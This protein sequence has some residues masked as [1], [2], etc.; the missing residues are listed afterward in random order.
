MS[1]T[2]WRD[3]L[4]RYQAATGLVHDRE[5]MAGR[6]RQLKHQW[7]F[8]NKLRYGSGLGHKEDGTVDASDEWWKQN[9]NVNGVSVS[10][11]F[12]HLVIETIHNK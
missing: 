12:Q 8:Y 7:T 5:Q 11:R 6:L 1:K 10:S 4:R 9:T 3:F 2:G